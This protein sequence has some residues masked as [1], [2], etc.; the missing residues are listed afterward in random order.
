[1]RRYQQRGRSAPACR[2]LTTLYPTFPTP[3]QNDSRLRSETHLNIDATAKL[4]VMIEHSCLL[5]CMPQ[6]GLHA[7]QSPR[8]TTA[9]TPTMS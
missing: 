3:R 9:P 2:M 5:M 1:M 7:A 4:I 6:G 8:V